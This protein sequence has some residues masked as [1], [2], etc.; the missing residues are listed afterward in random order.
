MDTNER[1]KALEDRVAQLEFELE[2]RAPRPA[3]SFQRMIDDERG[4]GSVVTVGGNNGG[5]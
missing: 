4:R 3:V 1:F 5:Y 2:K